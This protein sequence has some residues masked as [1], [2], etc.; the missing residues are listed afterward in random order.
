MRESALR[1]KDQAEHV[2]AFNEQHVVLTVTAGLVRGWGV[3]RKTGCLRIASQV[4]SI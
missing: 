1:I 3:R 2:F 4:R